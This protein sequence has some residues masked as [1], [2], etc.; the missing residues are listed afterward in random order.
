M[1][2]RFLKRAADGSLQWYH[3]N[4][5]HLLQE[6]VHDAGR[7][8]SLAQEIASVPTLFRHF[9]GWRAG[10]ILSEAGRHRDAWPYF[11]SISALAD[12]MTN[13]NSVNVE[14]PLDCDPPRPVPGLDIFNH[15]VRGRVDHRD[16][17]GE[18]VGGIHFFAVGRDGQ[19]P[20]A[21]PRGDGG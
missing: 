19:P 5:L 12:G 20:D 3:E 16:I 17:I 6:L 7:A 13:F 9:T 14:L 21:L 4:I 2:R 10:R 11:N 8:A 18:A 1:G 15:P